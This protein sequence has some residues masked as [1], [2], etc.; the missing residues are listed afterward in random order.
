[1]PEI[2][3]QEDFLCFA[4]YSKSRSTRPL[5]HRALPGV[6]PEHVVG[7]RQDDTSDDPEEPPGHVAVEQHD[8]AQDE[9]RRADEQGDGEHANWHGR[10]H[11]SVSRH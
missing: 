7:G 3:F 9:G 2:L 1:M 11:R 4:S 10:R 6:T 5:A 8:N